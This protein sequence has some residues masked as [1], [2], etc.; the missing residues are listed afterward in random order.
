MSYI[1]HAEAILTVIHERQAMSSSLQSDRFVRREM[2]VP[3]DPQN[4]LLAEFGWH[5]VA[6]GL[7]R[8]LLGYAIWILGL[9]GGIAAIVYYIQSQEGAGQHP[10]KSFDAG[11]FLGLGFLA[12]VSLFSYG[13]I[14]SG[15]WR[16]LMNAPERFAAK[17]L[18]FGCLFCLIIGPS[19]NVFLS[20]AGE[21][22]ANVRH[23]QKG[24]AGLAN[25][26]F[27]SATVMMQLASIGLTVASTTFF[28][29]FLRA[30]ALCFQSQA[31]V[32]L[33][34]LYL[35]FTCLLVGVTVQSILG[36]SKAV[37]NPELLMLLLGGWF[38]WGLWYLVA[39]VSVRSMIIQGLSNVRSPLD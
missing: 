3:V 19:M 17:W 26:E 37:A 24:K 1:C 32:W 36:M 35:M 29:L 30:A 34:N 9:V 10:K 21:G 14:I 39:I 28:V 12:V 31:C 38:I 7:G 4:P 27:T 5:R 25:I 15:K 8:I 20:V 2:Q 22:S 6:N 33:V 18:M 11:V 23:L 16:C 13:L